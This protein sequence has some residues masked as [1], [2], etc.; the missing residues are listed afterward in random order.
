MFNKLRNFKKSVNNLIKW[1]PIIWK[2]RDWDYEY[3][4]DIMSFKMKNMSELHRESKLP[5][6]HSESFAKDLEVASFLAD[7][8]SNSNYY[9]EVFKNREELLDNLKYK[10]TQLD[11][12][13]YKL[14]QYGLIEE[15]YKEY[16]NRLGKVDECLERDIRLLFSLMES[17]IQN[18][19]D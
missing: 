7:R 19:W 14:E 11:S 12:E 2:D 13:G 1:L 18:W 15:E 10:F 6:I 9:D 17:E 8:I 3:L 4:L 16:L 5:S